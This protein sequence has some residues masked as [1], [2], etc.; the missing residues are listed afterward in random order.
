MKLLLGPV[1]GAISDREARIWLR[2][3]DPSQARV[4]VFRDAGTEVPGSPFR[5]TGAADPSGT[6]TIVAHL[7]AAYSRY[8]YDVRDAAGASALPA[9]LGTPGFWSA[10]KPDTTGPFRFG[11]VSC[12][13]MRPK[14]QKGRTAAERERP[15]RALREGRRARP[16]LP[17]LRRGPDV[18]RRRVGRRGRQ[19][20]LPTHAAPRLP[21]RLPGA[22]G[23]PA[24]SAA[25]S[26]TSPA[27]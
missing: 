20:G 25:R 27:T 15:W 22:V 3:D 5:A 1:V 21:G 10:P 7:P 19:Q 23:L 2:A 12:N 11:V 9:W 14:S 13:D 4:H 8:T 26:P 18:R 16:R 17:A 24:G 6:A